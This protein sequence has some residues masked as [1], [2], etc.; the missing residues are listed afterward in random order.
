MSFKYVKSDFLLKD[1]FIGSLGASGDL[2]SVLVSANG[3]TA[4]SVATPCAASSNFLASLI[5]DSLP[6]ITLPL[7]PSMTFDQQDYIIN[8]LQGVFK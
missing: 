3:S 4:T 7:F 8:T 6:V 2:T 5:I 1:F